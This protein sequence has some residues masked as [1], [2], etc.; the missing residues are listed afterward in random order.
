MLLSLEK[1]EEVVVVTSFDDEAADKASK[2]CNLWR[3]EGLRIGERG[4]A[5]ASIFVSILT[6]G[7]AGDGL[8]PH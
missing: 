7:R 8:L 6:L 3:G 5:T 4:V 2:G 1:N